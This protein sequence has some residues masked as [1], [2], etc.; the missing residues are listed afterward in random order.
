MANKTELKAKLVSLGGE[1]GDMT[2]AQLEAAIKELEAVDTSSTK[3]DHPE[4]IRHR[5][6]KELR[7]K[8]AKEAAKKAKKLEEAKPKAE[9]SKAAAKKLPKRE[10]YEDDRGLKF[11]FKHSAPATLNLGGKTLK[12]SEIIKNDELMLELV[13]GN[14]NHIERIY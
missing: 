5:A 7:D 1:P 4:V 6:I 14:S 2:V 10:V 8:R 13:Y 11:A 12:T 3:E 9:Q